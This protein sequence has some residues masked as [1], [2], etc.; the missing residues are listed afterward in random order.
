M[1]VTERGG[2]EPEIVIGE[3]DGPVGTA[4]AML[5][6]DQVNGHAR[7]FAILNADVQVRPA[8]LMVS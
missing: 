1:K 7:I 5:V 2:G 4:L 6:G 8:T 3:L